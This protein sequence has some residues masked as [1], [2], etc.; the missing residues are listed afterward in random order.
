M[1]RNILL[2]F[3]LSTLV[4]VG[5]YQ[6]FPPQE[7]PKKA[8][9]TA[10]TLSAPATGAEAA[11][12]TASVTPSATLE[13]AG[14]ADSAAPAPL[15]VAK[16]VVVEAPHYQAV[17]DTNGGTLKA[18]Y[19]KD[20]LYAGPDPKPSNNWI[21]HLIGYK[22][23]TAYD[24]QRWV[25]MVG[26][27]Q[28]QWQV[29]PLKEQN[30]AQ[31]YGTSSERLEVQ[32]EATEL[33][34]AAN[35]QNGLRITKTL[36][37]HPEDYLIT[38][39]V[40]LENPTDNP[41]RV[42]PSFNMGAGNEIVEPDQFNHPQRGAAIVDGSFKTYSDSDFETPVELQKLRWAG[43]MDTYFIS[44]LK[45]QGE[46][47]FSLTLEGVEALA[48]GNKILVPTMLY[49]EPEFE[50]RSGQRYKKT[51]D[52]YLGPKVQREM[53]KYDQRLPA[54]LDLGWFDFLAYPM[55]A[56]LRWLFSLAH[57]WGVA[58]ILLTLVVRALLFPLAFKGMLSMRRMAKL[59]PRM[60]YLRDKY[61]NDKDRLNR[62]VMEL[63]KKNK[64]N[65][66]GGCLPLLMQVPV[67]IA[68]YSALMPAIELRHQGFALWLT[69]LSATDYTL[70]LPFLM[71]ASMFLQQ[72][73]TPQPAMDPVQ[74]KV[75]K[76]MPLVLVFFFLDMP[77]GLVLYWVV[78]NILTLFQQLFF[79]KI[80][81][82]EIEH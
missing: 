61:K 79:N 1:D 26:H 38:L 72:H 14:P 30:P 11:G 9:G 42:K 66:I 28:P 51:F 49:Q 56:V 65:P 43:V 10:T 52:L 68:L 54:S 40:A 36:T 48:H 70:I 12:E 33:V 13:A 34:L 8:A 32:G 5:Y 16:D 19:L 2:A 76:F 6:F 60:K 37:F 27:N 62:E 21:Y 50:L 82:A 53:E 55:L 41:I 25:N 23:K 18:F 59:N 24:P 67:F 35:L 75:M 29:L 31:F 57:N 15:A 3:L 74:A 71:G 44:A 64:V 78:S 20:Y 63:Y 4:L 58:I 69:D 81:E 17:I 80:K 45:P 22:E 39:Q 73:I 47:N 77:S 46:E 7:T